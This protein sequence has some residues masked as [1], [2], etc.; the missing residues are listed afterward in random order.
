MRTGTGLRVCLEP[1]QKGRSQ[2][3]AAPANALES[4]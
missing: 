1:D 2:P 3:V 4:L